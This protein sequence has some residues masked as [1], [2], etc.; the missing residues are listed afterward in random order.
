MVI[1]G[2]RRRMR[3]GIFLSKSLFFNLKMILT[4]LLNANMLFDHNH[5]VRTFK[6]IAMRRNITLRLHIFVELW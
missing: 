1:T 6:N 5:V 4:I 2:N 3:T